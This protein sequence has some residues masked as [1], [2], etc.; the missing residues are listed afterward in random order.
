MERRLNFGLGANVY[1]NLTRPS[2]IQFLQQQPA[3]ALGPRPQVS[4]GLLPLRRA[5]L[6][7]Q[8]RPRMT[9][10]QQFTALTP[11]MAPPSRPD[12][13][14]RSLLDG[15]LPGAGTPEAAGLGAAGQR[16]LELSGYTRVPRTMGEI[17]GEAAKA[18]T[19][20]RSEAAA[21]QAAAERQR[22]QDAI[23]ARREELELA[24]IQSQIRQREKPE[25]PALETIFDP[26][27]GREVKGYR[28]EV[29]RFIQVGGVKAEDVKTKKPTGFVA[30]YDKQG[31]FVKNVREGSP[32][33]DQFAERGFRIVESTQLSGAA[34]DVGLTTSVKGKLQTDVKDLEQ[35]KAGLANIKRDFDPSMQ[36]FMVR[37]EAALKALLEKGGVDLSAADQELV[38]SVAAY[39]QSAWDAANRYIK[40]L[41][42]AQMSEAE[43]QRILKSF[44]DPR[45]GLFEGDSPSAFKRKL[46]D[47]IDQ[48]NASL[49]RNYYFLNKGFD[50][51]LDSS[52]DL[53]KGEDN[54]IYI[55]DRGRKVGLDDME[56]IKDRETRRIA[57]KYESP[58]Y[59]QMSEDQKFD[60]I[61]AEVDALFN[62]VIG[63]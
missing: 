24:N 23:A 8:M 16:M 59:D 1:R 15:I 12:R 14:K 21:T 7:Q 2:A 11:P 53:E 40:Y 29:G 51:T 47:A 25:T 54:V 37:G 39:K 62:S 55:D 32:E 52:A 9:P 36:T 43:A 58:E 41:T 38:Q 49:A 19:T 6:E 3:P 44:P 48:V 18:Y 20:T 56:F 10:A 22:Q 50:I 17:L 13:P 42:G 5:V 33:A 45:L 61:E 27:T 26:A 35:A 28:N 34:K 63:A 30:V 60:A 46:D 57:E 4:Q 31:K